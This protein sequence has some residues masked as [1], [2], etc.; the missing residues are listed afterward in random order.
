MKTVIHY[1]CNL[2]DRWSNKR[3]IRLLALLLALAVPAPVLL[4]GDDDNDRNNE[5][6]H[7]RFVDS[8]NKEFKDS[9]FF[10]KLSAEWWQWALS[11]P[12]SVNPQID[13]DG[14]NAVV[15]QRGPVWF[16]AGV[17]FGGTAT[18]TC[19][20]PEGSALFFPVVNAINLNTPNVCSQGGTMT[21]SELRAAI[22]PIIDEAA[23][24]NPSVTLDGKAITN[25]PRVRSTVFAVALPEDNVFDVPCKSNVPAG[26]YSPGVGDGFYVLLNPLSTGKHT[27]RFHAEIPSQKFTE[28]VTYNIMIVPVVLP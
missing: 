25:L 13:S 14:K 10:K 22:A 3:L 1:L 12:T 6:E 7:G 9:E 24:A 16:L 15:G 11:I 27:L 5:K 19:S 2:Y 18:R 8:E 17:F 28:D 26:I 4:G 23:K 21:V 20:V